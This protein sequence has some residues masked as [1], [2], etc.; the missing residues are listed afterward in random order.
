MGRLCSQNYTYKDLCSRVDELMIEK[1]QDSSNFT[2]KMFKK[3]ASSLLEDYFEDI[4]EEKSKKYF[5]QT[6]HKKD[7]II[8][9]VIYDKKKYD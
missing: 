4:G 6:F 2:N 5:P 1:Y 7:R 8:L 9:N 3:A